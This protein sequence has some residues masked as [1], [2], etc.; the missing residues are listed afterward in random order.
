LRI[1]LSNGPNRVGVSLRSP[2][3]GNRSSFRK[4]VLFCVLQITGPGTKSKN[5]GIPNGRPSWICI[6]WYSLL[7]DV[8][9]LTRVFISHTSPNIW[10]VLDPVEIN[11]AIECN[12]NRARGVSFHLLVAVTLI[13][14]RG[15]LCTSEALV[16]GCCRTVRS[17]ALY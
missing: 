10:Y 8:N 13:W 12:C 9:T 7:S 16:T 15:V 6:L 1:A 2:G 3:D 14:H 4:V 17:H 5:W 11:T